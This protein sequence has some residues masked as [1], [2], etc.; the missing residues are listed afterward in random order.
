MKIKPYI[1]A[2][3][4]KLHLKN[5]DDYMNLKWKTFEEG[6]AKNFSIYTTDEYFKV[7]ENGNTDPEMINDMAEE[8]IIGKTI[9]DVGAFIGLSSLVFSKISDKSKIICFEPNPYNRERIKANFEK[10]KE[11]S[12]NIKMYPYALSNKNEN[13]NMFLSK[14]IEGPSSTSRITG[15]HSTISNENLPDCFE[16][17]VVESKTLDSFVIEEKIHPDVMKIDIEG[18][19]Y[20]L[21]LGGLNTLKKY[22]PLLYIELHSEYCALKCSE[23][24]ITLGYS[25]TV[26]KEESDNRIMVKA[27]CNNTT[28]STEKLLNYE[29]SVMSIENKIKT[30][31]EMMSNMGEKISKIFSLQENMIFKENEELKS[32]VNVLADKNQEAQQ[33]INKLQ[34]EIHELQ[35][36]IDNILKSK[37]WKVTEPLRKLRNNIKKK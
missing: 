29:N 32:K 37:S 2:L 27:K 14:I 6:N 21:L 18:A 33:T 20:M 17:I 7:Y 28:E 11:F 9:F 19:E 1:K 26:L 12:K 23:L 25:L 35:T 15:S 31:N 13:V 5:R 16:N 8:N 36:Q 22:H 3:R 4:R 34:I 30:F 10:N 24:L